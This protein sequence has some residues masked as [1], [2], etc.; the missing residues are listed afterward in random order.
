MP[1]LPV[2]SGREL[3]RALSGLG[4]MVVRQRGSHIRLACPGRKS[5]T[6]PDYKTIDR[7]LI[8]K[9]LRD[10]RIMVEDFYQLL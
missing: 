5:I 9:I 4:Y 10:A 6:V 7:S 2:M 3:V 8:R 1:Q